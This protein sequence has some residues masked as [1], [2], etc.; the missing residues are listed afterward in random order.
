MLGAAQNM[1]AFVRIL[2][3]E[4]HAGMRAKVNV[5]LCKVFQIVGSVGDGK[6]AVDATL[7]LDPDILILGL[8]LPVMNG[9]EVTARLWD[10]KCRTRI[11]IL[12]TFE[13]EEH[14]NGA[15]SF[16]AKAYVTKRHVATD[17]VTAVHEVLRGNMF[18]SPS[19]TL[20]SPDW[21]RFAKNV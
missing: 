16:G 7:Q 10:L 19:L 1:V 8:S 18:V 11:V 4:A 20:V 15:F 12:S 13:D 3:A 2:L 17:L 5:E 6:Q 9:F 14:I 21:E